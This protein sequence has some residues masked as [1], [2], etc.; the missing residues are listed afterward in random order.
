MRLRLLILT[1]IIFCTS[2]SSNIEQPS[3]SEIAY[4]E[5]YVWEGLYYIDDNIY[6]GIGYIELD[7]Q[8][9]KEFSYEISVRI[10]DFKFRT[11]GNA[12]LENEDLAHDEKENIEF[13]LIGNSLA[14][15]FID[16]QL[17][18]DYIKAFN[19]T[20]EDFKL[21]NGLHKDMSHEE[22]KKIFNYNEQIEFDLEGGD[23]EE[24]GMPVFSTVK[25]EGIEIVFQ[26]DPEVISESVIY[27]YS[28]TNENVK[29]HR[30]I[31]VGDTKEKSF[32]EIW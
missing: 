32:G 16:E 12:E 1:V 23:G 21:S 6:E 30:N 8:S 25:H 7:F 15:T 3:D 27:Q 28:I 20:N 9:E 17:T 4:F 5:N 22:F 11:N 24:S 14:I 10:S 29:T 26:A 31:G 18:F 2:C 19:L 13:E